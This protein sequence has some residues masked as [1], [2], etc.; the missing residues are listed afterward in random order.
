[1]NKL[2]FQKIPKIPKKKFPKKKIFT[3]K[4][5]DKK[6]IRFIKKV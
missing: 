1:M 6:T 5:F 4:Y 2:F 3:V